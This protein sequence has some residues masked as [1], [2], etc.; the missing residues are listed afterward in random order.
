MPLWTSTSRAF[1][2]AGKLHEALRRSPKDDRLLDSATDLIRAMITGARRCESA[3]AARY[4]LYLC[5]A[6]GGQSG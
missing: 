2:R 6:T 5:A 1:A 3:P 4:A